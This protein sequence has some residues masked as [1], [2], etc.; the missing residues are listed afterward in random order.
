[1]T[2]TRGEVGTYEIRVH[3]TLGPLLLSTLPHTAATRVERH[4]LLITGPTSDA[5][6]VELMGMIVDS[7]LEVDSIRAI[8][9]AHSA[10]DSAA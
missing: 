3:G 10:D 9:E 5:D 1:M 2:G 8:V 4:S 7:G 6:L